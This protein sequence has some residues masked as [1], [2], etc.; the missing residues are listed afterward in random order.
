AVERFDAASIELPVCPW[1]L[2]QGDADEVVSPQAVF[3]WAM[4]LPHPPSIAVL[5][6]AGHFYHGRLNELRQTVV[7]YFN[8]D[9]G[10]A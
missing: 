10:D 8:N 5:K 3:D 9:S 1:L 4:N 2:I 7:D 6:G